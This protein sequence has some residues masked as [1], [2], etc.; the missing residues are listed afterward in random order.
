MLDSVI[1]DVDSSMEWLTEK[2]FDIRAGPIESPLADRVAGD[3]APSDVVAAIALAISFC[4][5]PRWATS[6]E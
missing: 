1:A 2:Q 5:T 3:V 6:F 4:R